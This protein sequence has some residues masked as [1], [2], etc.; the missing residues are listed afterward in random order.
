M[1]RA[2]R[3]SM[4]VAVGAR[5]DT[6]RGRVR[7]SCFSHRIRGQVSGLV[8]RNHCE[9]PGTAMVTRLSGL[10]RSRPELNLNR[11]YPTNARRR[12]EVPRSP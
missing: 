10:G 5:V 3:G 8:R 2:G 6:G 9:S 1:E 11:G 4:I 12:T 7:I